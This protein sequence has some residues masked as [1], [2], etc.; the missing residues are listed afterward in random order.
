[1]FKPKKRKFMKTQ[2]TIKSIAACALFTCSTASFAQHSGHQGHTSAPAP[3]AYAGEQ[4][5]SI[6]ALSQSDIS[7]LQAGAGMAYA[8]AA[9]LNGYPGPAHVLELKSQLQLSDQ[10]RTATEALMAS[11]QAQARVLGS[12]L[13]E[14]ERALDLAFASKSANAASVATLT[15]RIGAV[16]AELRAEHLQTHL[17]QTAMLTPAQIA[18]YSTL[19][20]YDIAAPKTGNAPNHIH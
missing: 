1:L 5:R 14:A 4:T 7:S 11:H 20:G 10:Q 8:K 16:Q 19:R 12:Q 15:Q 17:K 3:S 6:K 18:S 13:V 9:E 2:I